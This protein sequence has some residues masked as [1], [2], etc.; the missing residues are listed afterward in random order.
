MHA[1]QLDLA[2]VLSEVGVIKGPPTAKPFVPTPS[3][4]HVV[5]NQDI[6]VKEP[7]R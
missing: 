5:I 4:S 1:S 3:H 7:A 6:N 2:S